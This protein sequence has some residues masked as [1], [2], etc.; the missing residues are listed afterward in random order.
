MFFRFFLFTKYIKLFF[1]LGDSGGPLY[2]QDTVNGVTKYVLAGVV[3]YGDGCAVA[4][5][6]GYIF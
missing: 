1:I 2:V 4:G 3:S 5:Y 6:P